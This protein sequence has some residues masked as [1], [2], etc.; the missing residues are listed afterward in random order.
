[1]KAMEQREF[2]STY[3]FHYVINMH[4]DSNKDGFSGLFSFYNTEKNV[5]VSFQSAPYIYNTA[6]KYSFVQQLL[7]LV[8]GKIVAVCN[9]SIF[10]LL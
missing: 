7:C 6:E 10:M 5:R 9:N 2:F 4:E 1:M 3:N 8:V